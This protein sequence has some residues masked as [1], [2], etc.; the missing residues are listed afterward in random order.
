MLGAVASLIFS[1]PSLRH[2]AR[3]RACAGAAE[4]LHTSYIHIFV[5]QD[6]LFAA[7]CDCVRWRW[8]VA[9][10]SPCVAAL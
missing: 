3:V 8:D 9:S 5:M 6:L 10:P 4:S 2:F 7:L 1:L